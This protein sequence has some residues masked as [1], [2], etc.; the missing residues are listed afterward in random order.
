MVRVEKGIPLSRMEYCL[1]P[2]R[3]IPES[4]WDKGLRVVGVHN[5]GLVKLCPTTAGCWEWEKIE[6]Y[7]EETVKAVLEAVDPKDGTWLGEVREKV[8]M[9]EPMKKV[10]LAAFLRKYPDVFRMEVNTSGELDD[11]LVRLNGTGKG[12]AKEYEMPS[13]T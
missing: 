9:P 5:N 6:Y 2:A 1:P 11:I 8:V 13:W 4:K 7:W 3:A 12:E 10:N